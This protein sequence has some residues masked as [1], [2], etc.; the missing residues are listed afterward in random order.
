[1]QMFINCF[2]L[3]NRYKLV[4][5]FCLAPWA[6]VGV[7]WKL[8]T[9]FSK[10][11]EFTFTGKKAVDIGANLASAKHL[12]NVALWLRRS[13][14]LPIIRLLSGSE[15]LKLFHPVCRRHHCGAPTRFESAARCVAEN[16]TAAARPCAA[17]LQLLFVSGFVESWAALFVCFCALFC[18][19]PLLPAVLLLNI[20]PVLF[21]CLFATVYCSSSLSPGS[22]FSTLLNPCGKTVCMKR[23][24]RRT[25]R[26]IDAVFDK[27]ICF[28]K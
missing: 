8:K 19:R 21:V 2:F 3:L 6:Q 23:C 4:P 10:S 17:Q 11:R 14:C 20:Y 25:R 18:S 12:C 27:F 28:R 24:C 15:S 22:T 9:T 16:P 1:M 13:Y 5:A 7:S 26:K